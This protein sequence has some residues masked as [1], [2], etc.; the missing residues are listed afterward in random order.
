MEL[1][2]K[3]FLHGGKIPRKYTCQGE[4]I[5]PSLEIHGVPKDA[6]TLALILEDPDVPAFVR[7][8]QMWDHWVVFNIDP[9][10]TL[11]KENETNFGTFGKNTSG[12]DAYE[13]PCPPDREHRYF[14]KLFAL[15]KELDLPKGCSKKNLEIAMQGHILA[16][17]EL[18]GTYV[19]I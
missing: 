6:K 4:G 11:I 10:T 3:A 1:T 13:G 18:M 5:S 15:D 14:F 16:Q 17:S 9:K 2:S 12:A 19:K 8:D 7:K